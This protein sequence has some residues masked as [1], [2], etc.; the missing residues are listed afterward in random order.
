MVFWI[1]ALGVL[2]VVALLTVRALNQAVERDTALARAC[3]ANSRCLR[4]DSLF[5]IA[6][7]T[8]SEQE[9]GRA[10][11]DAIQ[12]GLA[13]G[14]EVYPDPCWDVQCPSCGLHATFDPYRRRLLPG[15]A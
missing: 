2:V 8:A 5:G 10:S 15:S 1:G 9:H 14:L 4:C 6:V 7:A 13:A 3:V 11:A 12:E